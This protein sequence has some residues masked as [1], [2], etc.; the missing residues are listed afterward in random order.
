MNTATNSWKVMVAIISVGVIAG[1][2]FTST[3][4]LT[5]ELTPVTL[6]QARLT[7][8]ALSVLIVM[9]LLRT[10]IRLSPAMIARVSVLALLDGVI[11]YL[12]I[13][14]AAGAVEAGVAGVLV[15]TMPMFTVMIAGLTSRDEGIAASALLGIGV[16]VAGVAV[17][18]GPGVLNVGDSSPIGMLIILI[19]TVSYAAGTVYARAL[20][21]TADPIGLT[22]LKLVLASLI[23]APLTFVEGSAAGVASLSPEGWLSLA[24]LGVGA[25]GLGRV[26][27]LFVVKSAGSVRASLVTYITP[28][29]GAL[30]GWVVLGEG[31]GPGMIAGGALITS[32]VAIVMYGRGFTAAV[33]ARFARRG[34]ASGPHPAMSDQPRLSAV[35]PFSGTLNTDP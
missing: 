9:A 18:T 26:L 28:V 30:L 8:A 13:S 3:K 1:S 31:L 27:Y 24:V 12:L 22:G 10:E 19:A 7:T 17:L 14:M 16:G 34:P 23:L 15:S 32:G 5:A 21:R 33:A 4:L 25:T 29:V 11:P 2:A 35:G 6:A 20:L